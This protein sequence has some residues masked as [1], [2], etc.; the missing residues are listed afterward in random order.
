MKKYRPLPQKVYNVCPGE[1]KSIVK[2]QKISFQ[3]KNKKIFSSTVNKWITVVV[4]RHC[5]QR[6]KQQKKMKFSS[7][8]R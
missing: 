1:T 4:V 2:V 3:M 8:L 7:A 6:S 5:S